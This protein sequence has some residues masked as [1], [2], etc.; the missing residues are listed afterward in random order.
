M[1]PALVSV[2]VPCYNHQNFVIDCINSICAQDYESVELIIID[3]GSK[4]N[5]VIEIKKSLKRCEARFERFEFR[6]RENK[7]LCATLNEALS[8]CRGEFCIVIA[9][10]DIM[11]SDRISKQ[12][13]VF[14]EKKNLEPELVAIYSGVEMIDGDGQ[15]IKNKYGN[16]S[17]SSFKDVFLRT[18]FLPTPTC[19]VLTD[20]LRASGGY[21]DN[22]KI[23]DF[24]IRVKLTVNGG[25][26]YT[27][28][29]PLVKY[30][31]HS[32]NM[33]GKSDLIWNGV[34]QILDEYKSHPLYQKALAMSMMIHA[35]DLQQYDNR[36]ALLK[37]F[38][39]VKLSSSVI[40]TKSMLKILIKIFIF[41]P[42]KYIK[43]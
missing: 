28:K 35:H 13:S 43:E 41:T 33:S 31:M 16:N 7:G 12:V 22:F 17:F 23:E 1:S 29:Q 30:R 38:E 21:N 37:I 2:I 10:D 8:W 36:K 6:A 27:I 32:D 39:A 26:F 19:M 18:E 24:Y 15:F 5:S 14:Y 20:K 40:L 34:V 4:D 42:V 9:S 25:K 3:D 11:N